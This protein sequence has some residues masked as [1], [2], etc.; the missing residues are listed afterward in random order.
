MSGNSALGVALARP[1]SLY[2]PVPPAWPQVVVDSLEAASARAC[3]FGVV[4]IALHGFL[5]TTA[6]L[7]HRFTWP[8]SPWFVPNVCAPTVFR[9]Y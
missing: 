8:A 2:H 5:V 4:R 7:C 3:S 1:S 6:K 9:M